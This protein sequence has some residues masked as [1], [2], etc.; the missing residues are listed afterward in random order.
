VLA[1]CCRTAPGARH[2]IK[3]AIHEYYGTYDRMAMDASLAGPEPAEGWAAFRERRSPS[4]VHPDL[5]RDG[6]L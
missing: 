4:W 3:R 5:R 2:E 1:Q 6:R